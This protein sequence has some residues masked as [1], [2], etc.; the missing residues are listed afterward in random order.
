MQYKPNLLFNL[1]AFY[2]IGHGAKRDFIFACK[3]SPAA[4]I[5]S[6]VDDEVSFAP[7]MCPQVDPMVLRTAPVTPGTN[8][9]H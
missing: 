6:F 9:G 4:Q 2:E 1:I 7:A 5:C 8:A 3:S